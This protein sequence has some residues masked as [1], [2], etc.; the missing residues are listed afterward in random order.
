MT[1]AKKLKTKPDD[2]LFVPLG[3]SGEIGMNLNLYGYQDQWIMVDLGITFMNQW[4]IEVAMPDISFAESLGKKLLGLVVTHGHEDHIGAIPYLWSRLNCPI[5]ATP[6]TAF[7]IR[8][9]LRDVGL[10]TQVKIIEVT[11]RKSFDLGAFNIEYVPITHSI[12]EAN[13]IKIDTPQGRIM[14]TGDWKLDDAPMVGAETDVE[15]LKALG[16]EGV[17]ALVCDSTNVFQEGRSGSEGDVR[18]NLIEL[19][20]KQKKLV[21][22]SCFASNVARLETCAVAARELGRHLV[23]AGRSLDRMESAAR[24]AGYLKGIPKFYKEDAL[25]ELPRDKVLL[26]CTGSQGEPRSALAR[27]AN[28]SHPKIRLKP[29]ETVIFSSRMIPGND[30]AIKLMQERLIDQGLIVITD[31]DDFTHVSGH[32][33]QDELKDMYSWLKPQILIP[34]HGEK[35][36]MREHVAFGMDCG[37]PMAHMPSNGEVIRLSKEGASVIDHVS[38]GQWGL[39]G[40]QIVPLD[41][42]EIK[43][44]AKLLSG[45]SIFISLVVGKDGH[46]KKMPQITMIGVCDKPEES[47]I[48]EAAIQAVEHAINNSF[49]DKRKKQDLGEEIRTSVRRT[50]NAYRGKKPVVVVHLTK[51]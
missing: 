51:E 23:I 15:A 11:P 1:Q 46:L 34:V 14:H 47:E 38:V 48:H 43:E 50:M 3:G 24:H 32:P 9:K 45:G 7:L 8:E 33:Y 10:L 40:F 22:V 5:Y 29:D 28:Q 4:G 36:H 35:I 31:Q 18:D 13:V 26:V 44:R 16:G 41:S 12:P 27:I 2:L 17:L 37:I 20:S 39:D 49:D 19:I 42:Q 21:A 25:S 30:D 6:F